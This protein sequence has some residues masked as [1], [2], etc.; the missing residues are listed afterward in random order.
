MKIALVAQHSAPVPT[1][2]DATTAG[3]DARLVE[4]SKSLAGEGHQVTVYARRSG[5]ALP[6]R[7][8]LPPA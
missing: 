1:D 4:M 8:R 6:A 3:E 5:K 7:A 2:T